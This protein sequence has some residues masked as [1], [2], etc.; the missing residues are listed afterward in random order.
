MKKKKWV[1][2]LS[3]VLCISLLTNQMMGYALTVTLLGEVQQVE[4]EASEN[5]EYEILQNQ[6]AEQIEQD[7][8]AVEST[9]EEGLS[10]NTNQD[11]I[12]STETA[13]ENE[14]EIL[15]QETEN[16]LQEET[17]DVYEESVIKIYNFKQLEAI[18]S[19]RVV[20][21]TD[22][23]EESFGTGNPVQENGEDI[24]YSLE[25]S[26]EL[27]ND[28][29]LDGKNLWQLP[30]DFVG[31]FVS[32]NVSTQNPIYDSQ[33]DTLY[34]YH[35]YQIETI[36]SD[37]ASM[38]PVLSYDADP[39]QF[40]IGQ[41][42]Y[43]DNSS[44]YLT[45]SPTHHY[46]LSKFFTAERPELVAIRVQNEVKAAGEFQNA[47]LSGRDYIGQVYKEMNGEKYI[48][49]G[50]RLQLQAVGSDQQVTPMLFI[51]KTGPLGIGS[52]YTPLYPGDADFSSTIAY[53]N[54]VF[55]YYESD[56]VKDKLMNVDWDEGLLDFVT[57]LLGGVLGSLLGNASICGYDV[58]AGQPNKDID[59]NTLKAEYSDLKYSSDA[60]YIVFRDIDLENQAWTPLMFSG[61]MIGAKTE[62]DEKLWD[63]Q[64]IIAT[65]QPVISNVNVYQ[66]GEI[67][68][69]KQAGI[70]FFGTISNQYT[71]Q[72][73]VSNQTV[74]VKNLKLLNVSVKNESTSIKDNTGLISGLLNGLDL[75]L[76]SLLGD[77]EKV[78]SILL[79][80][81]SNPDETIFATGAFVGRVSGDVIVE[82]CVVENLTLLSNVKDIT[83][84]FAG[85]V[86]G[87]VEYGKLQETLGTTVKIL[88]EVLNI[89]PFLDLGTLI[90]VLLD[91]NIIN[92]DQLIPTGYYNP[93]IINCSIQ[94]NTLDIASESTNFNG[95]FVG[96]QVGAIIKDSKVQINQLTIKGKNLVGGF[97]GLTADGELVGVLES[98]GVDLMNSI[99]LN[100]YLLNATVDTDHLTVE[101][102]KQY[103][104]GLSGSFNN[105]F[106]IDSSID[107]NVTVLAQSYAGGIA[108]RA[109]IAQSLT[110]GSEFYNGKYDV[111]SLVGNVLSGVLSG[112]EEHALL[113]LTGV[114]PSVI[115]GNS[116]TGTLSVK[117]S[118]SYAGGFVGSAD[119][120]KLI[121]SND[122]KTESFIWSQVSS[123]MT[124]T[125]QGLTNTMSS[126]ESVEA[127][128]YAGGIVGQLKTA[129]AAGI[130]NQT[131]G[132]GNYLSFKVDHVTVSGVEG[133]YTIQAED[134]F[135]GGA[136]G[137]AV[138]GDVS[139][140]TLEHIAKVSAQNYVGG[141]VG[142]AGAGSLV[143]AGSLNLLGL[144]LL[145]VT[146]LLSIADGIHTNF[147]ACRVNGVTTGLNIS[148]TGQKTTANYYAGGF[149][150]ENSASDIENSSVN[151]L[152]SVSTSILNMNWTD[153][154]MTTGYAGGFAAKSQVGGLASVGDA[155]TVNGLLGDVININH[156]LNVISY[157]IPTYTNCYVS[158]VENESGAN[159]QSGIAGGF[160]GEMMGGTIDN[161]S[162][163]NEYAVRQL[164][165]VEG[166]YYAGGFAGKVISGGLANSD[167]L[168]VLGTSI[169]I[170]NLLS[171]V[172]VYIPKIKHAGVSSDGLRVSATTTDLLDADS[173]SA[174][175][176]A[177]LVKGAQIQDSDVNKL[178]TKQSEKENLVEESDYAI[179][180]PT[181]AGGYAGKV[182]IGSATA[183][184][185]GLNLLGLVQINNLLSAIDAVASEIESCD[186]Y[187]AVGGF[188]ILSTQ[189]LA[190]GY[191]GGLYGSKLS[192]SD[193]YNFE[194]IEGVISAGGYAGSIEPGSVADVIDDVK[195]L[196]GLVSANDV[197]GL[198]KAFIPMILN[199]ETTAVPCGGY[200]IATG[201]S[202]AGSL[203]GLA[204][205]YVGYNLGGSIV[206]STKY[207]ASTD[208]KPC[209]AER[210]RLVSGN[211]FAGGYTGL[212]QTANIAETG[213]LSLL[214]RVQVD[215]LISALEG[216]YG[217][218]TNTQV[219]GPLRG[220][221]LEVWNSWVDRVGKYGAYGSQMKAF[222]NQEELNQFIND[223]AYGYTVKTLVED[224]GTGV[225]DGGSAGGYV[226]RME[227]GVISNAWAQDVKGVNSF[228]S[229]GGF[230][231]EIATG[232]VGNLGSISLG[233]LDVLDN[234]GL[235][236]SFVPVIEGSQVTGYQSGMTITAT[237]ISNNE[238]VGNAGGFVGYMV[239]GQI[240]DLTDH[241]VTTI[242]QVNQLR[243]VKGRKYVGGFAG[244][245]DSGSSIAVDTQ[246]N[247]GLLNQLLRLV[248]H[249]SDVS[250][251]LSVLNATRSVIESV[252][253]NAWDNW[254]ITIDGT[255]TDS[256]LNTQYA[257]AAGGFVGKV[258][259]AM[260]GDSS[261]QFSIQINQ[262]RTVI[263]GMNAG[264]FVGMADVDSVIELSE[265]SSTSILG[266]IGL[267]NT[268][269][270][271]ALR[272]AIDS[273]T[274]NGSNDYGLIVRAKAY[275]ENSKTGDA[276]YKD[277]N[278]G[279]FG[280]SL[281]N[282][283]VSN[284]HV[285]GLREVESANYTG[286]FIGLTGKSGVLDID[287][288]SL[289]DK[290]LG[291]SA[292]V[293]DLFGSSIEECSVSGVS[294]GFSVN[295]TSGDD[296]IA[297]GFIGYGDL[298]RIHACEVDQLKKV[299]SD[300]M[301]GGFIGKTS[302]D[303]LVDANA[304]SPVLLEAVLL[305]VNQLLDILYVG[306]LENVDAISVT[307]PGLGF[308][309]LSLK[310]LSEGD[311]LSVTLLG[312][313]ISVALVKSN[314]DGSSDVA[315]IH[316][317]DS[318]VEVP[319]Y[320]GDTHIKEED[321][322]QIKIGLIK[323]NRT[324]V[325]NS[326]VTGI[327][328]GYDVFV[329]SSRNELLDG[330]A[331][332][333]VGYNDEGLFENNQMYYADVIENT[334][335]SGV[336]Y[337]GPFSGK[338]SLDTQYESINNIQTIEGQNN[339]YRIYRR[340]IGYTDLKLS[341]QKVL[342]H[343][344][345]LDPISGWN[346]FTIY[347]IVDVATYDNF[348][349]AIMKG[350]NLVD[351]ALNAY[352][353][354]SKMKLMDGVIA[355][356]DEKPT[357]PTPPEAQDPCQEYVNLSVSK[358][359]RD[360]NNL[361]NKRPDKITITLKRSWTENGVQQEE[362]VSG[363]ENYEI[364]GSMNQNTWEAVLDQL[365]AYKIGDDGDIYY[366]TYSV[367]ET[368]VVD[369]QTDSIQPSEDGFA[370]TITNRYTLPLPE[371]GGRGAAIFFG[372][373]WCLLFGVTILTWE[374]KRRTSS[375]TEENALK[376]EL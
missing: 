116:I 98:L 51:H 186:V 320:P 310:V 18:G 106:S 209:L 235:V 221:T 362:V 301:T 115:A 344:G 101:A 343:I 219:T 241:D 163:G 100:S 118:E 348:K 293:L 299:S 143:E 7:M 14:K 135:S 110:L 316:I 119:G 298:A 48:L 55:K 345:Q 95:G 330:Y 187:G 317:G 351:Q 165:S 77:L 129:S 47:E 6:D 226:G 300:S 150:G 134:S 307:I 306:D 352:I 161:T 207:D 43:S 357:T 270:L 374:T 45:Y 90:E 107:G 367:S 153:D 117:T 340:N 156:L 373:G 198:A 284:S 60:N 160:I 336:S 196:G 326:I 268:D 217:I 334:G 201:T 73:G 203:K 178:A 9:Q 285:Y 360:Q 318:Y 185:Q 258:S 248:I 197:L 64:S 289:L 255:Y 85:N 240:K 331:G 105:S 25:A 109:S 96:R 297:G 174:G 81:S 269:I 3:V 128:N 38:E 259:G 99:R 102:V 111:T 339:V 152:R 323:A 97:S 309:V 171:V 342:T 205:G 52:T 273:A 234:L 349:G 233:D 183:V 243:A 291:A 82:D 276:T 193:S 167:G 319:C 188:N 89:L 250:S 31:T 277:G 308:D 49:I 140:I 61:T 75:I 56:E 369:Y 76:G 120:L 282:S 32:A 261:R 208:D 314:E 70:G 2:Y 202:E 281:L 225:L 80:P 65:N 136:F 272:P 41:L 256:T 127:Q 44:E 194:Y 149:I 274:V 63:D 262:L 39:A 224:D 66:T 121:S 288:V 192:H 145:K 278:A 247:N 146:S 244:M 84:G 10:E 173:G 264:G 195:V 206:G 263:G 53:N 227:G 104:G 251:L 15:E 114:S 12:S 92:I 23:I 162:L 68:N 358:V 260:I 42:V 91:G 26:Y 72:I 242:T 46:V 335:E 124:Y 222:T 359:W 322:D 329:D 108:G 279:G 86:E 292:G 168:S 333:F 177:G 78:L 332:G 275:T 354:E 180:A 228:R 155:D 237:A 87:V 132:I 17:C 347:H 131:L 321:K 20:R 232:T 59:E 328:S 370:F 287:N 139:N 57:G 200:I 213:S 216:I 257:K 122:L 215:N 133:G 305:V 125:P 137:Q 271:N 16:F 296:S 304:S 249:S 13:K 172:D 54:T 148:S 79:N 151:N 266:L 34:I 363:Y 4:A 375:A 36:L 338:T 229:A 74:S 182:D 350:D 313:K 199:S 312:L 191:V 267:G 164:S 179:V 353:S 365:P 94:G 159:V 280:G 253:I 238:R 376:E 113:S 372:I 176:Y 283:M 361:A 154:V 246:S 231:G 71:N 356:E 40:G 147:T 366:Y 130:L 302:Y 295:S 5:Q 50:N 239:G 24:L 212:M 112:E 341:D 62:N 35:L 157:L 223:Y 33:T 29:E 19:G 211:E 138:G 355:S 67:D 230:A 8:T 22:G 327:A 181:Y 337:I 303:Y 69:Q 286:G 30:S 141:F 220:L 204:G 158:F 371:T 88:E 346:V 1:H 290:L 368:E 252:E 28:I 245:I 265:D 315:Q 254:G 311:A 184:G 126:L 236:Q 142:S 175:G 169:S 21:D 210:I 214:G 83:G 170:S 218:Q 27:M 103:A 190:G 166:S 325:V 37:Q 58:E 189:G 93:Q 294:T 364:T 11:T 324:K 144:D 123:S